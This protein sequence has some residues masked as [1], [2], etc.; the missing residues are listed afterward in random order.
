MLPST[1]KYFT[2][3][4]VKLPSFWGEILLL[5]SP[6]VAHRIFSLRALIRR[7]ANAT[8]PSYLLTSVPNSQVKGQVIRAGWRG[9]IPAEK[10]R[11][12]KS[13][14]YWESLLQVFPG[15][16]LHC[17][18]LN[19][20]F[21]TKTPKQAVGWCRLAASGLGWGKQK[22]AMGASAEFPVFKEVER[23]SHPCPWLHKPWG[24]WVCF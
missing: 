24:W 3:F 8:T 5:L 6:G 1:L 10:S 20:S 15:E 12:Q 22:V 18:G 4:M 7:E 11:A 17:S 19:P 16:P 21:V 13:P 14:C 23:K 9:W 2:D